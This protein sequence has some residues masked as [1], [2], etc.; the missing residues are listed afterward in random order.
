[1]KGEKENHL[2]LVFE[3]IFLL[4]FVFIQF[5]LNLLD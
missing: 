3:F 5:D 2:K 1:M 4:Y